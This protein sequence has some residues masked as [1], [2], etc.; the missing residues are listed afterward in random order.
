MRTSLHDVHLKAGAKV[1]DFHGWDMPIQYSSIIDE[2]K[3]VRT[4]VGLFD[5]SHMGRVFITGPDRKKFLQKLVTIDVAGM[6]AGRCKY[7]FFLTEKGTVIDD[8]IASEDAAG[9]ACFLVVNASNREKDLEWMRR[10]AGGFDVKIDDATERLQLVA[11][12]GPKSVDLVKTALG[13]D[14]SGLKY[15]T[16]DRFP[17]FGQPTLVSRTGYTGEDGFEIYMARDK[18]AAVWDACVAKGGAFGLRPIGLGARDTLRTEA[19]MP[20]YGNDIDDQTT[21]VEAGLNFALS[22]K[23]DYLGRPVIDAQKKGGAPRRLVGFAMDGKRIS[24]HG[25]DVFRRGDK[26]GVVTSGTWSPSLEKSI[27]MA[28][29]KNGVE[30]AVEIDVRG[31]REKAAIVPMPFYKRAKSGG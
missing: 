13:F 7:T 16:L 17:V 25:M 10:H 28:M 9:D 1:V 21:P 6:P 22:D 14:P 18:A 11:V 24:R 2:H 31:K 19:S 27:G 20:L 12:Q 5:L 26:V 15:Y 8:L 3:A 29:L 23:A 4:A 30:G